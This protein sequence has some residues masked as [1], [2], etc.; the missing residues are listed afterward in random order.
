MRMQE[1]GDPTARAGWRLDLVVGAVVF[2]AALTLYAVTLRGDVQAA[3]AGELQVAAWTLSIPHPPGY[4]L[5]TLLAWAASHLPIGASPYVRISLLSALTSALGAGLLAALVASTRP[6]GAWARRLAGLAAGLALAT[7]VTF[8][9]QATTANIRSLTALFSVG[10]VVAIVA[11][12]ASRREQDWRARMAVNGVSPRFRAAR[13]VLLI[14]AVVLGLGVGHHVS[15]VFPGAVLGAF[16]LIAYLRARASR[17]DHTLGLLAA[18]GVFAAC[19][20][21]WLLLPLRT[22]APSPLDHGNLASL[23]GFLNHALARGFEGDF[24]YFVRAAPELL[25]ERLALLPQLFGFQFSPIALVVMAIGWAGLI[26]RRRP[27][28]LTLAGALGLHLFITLTYRAPQTVEYALPAWVIAVAG[29]G[30]GIAALSIPRTVPATGGG[31]SERD[32]RPGLS[33]RERSTSGSGVSAGLAAR[34]RGGAWLV[35]GAALTIVAI[36]DGISHFA[37][38]AQ[39][40]ADRSDRALAEAA[41]AATPQGGTILG[42]W[43]QITPIWAL[44]T[45]E[46]IRPDVQA[47]YVYPEGAEPYE[48]TFARRAAEASATV[49]SVFNPQF[50][51]RGVCVD[52][53]GAA[54][55]WRTV[56]CVLSVASDASSIVFDQRI[57]LVALEVGVQTEPGASLLARVAWRARGPIQS[58]D[59][60]TIRFLYPDGRLASN[61]DIRLPESQNVGETRSQLIALGIPLDFGPGPLDIR[62]GAYRPANP[63]FVQ[64]ADASGAQFPIAAR[65][66]VVAPSAPPATTRPMRWPQSCASGDRPALIGLDYD[67]GIPGKMRVYT[68]WTTGVV[69]SVTL[70]SP[71]AAPATASPP[72]AD[73]CATLIFDTNPANGLTLDFGG[74]VLALPDPRPGER[75]LPFA[76]GVTL[77]GARIRGDDASVTLDWLSGRALTADYKIS[78]RLSGGRHDGTPA[79]GA[80]PSLKWIAGTRVSDFHP[81]PLRSEERYRVEGD[82]KIYDNFS[83]LPLPVLDPRYERDGAPLFRE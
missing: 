1:L 69:A 33:V 32:R 64:Y 39:L 21:V 72:A 65:T 76:D 57:A 75:Y 4:P 80:V 23:D 29:A 28:G 79:L 49:L 34:L 42:Q 55:I 46:G 22:A 44:Q 71:V 74:S 54:P 7:S 52:P 40:A 78:A 81:M 63:G 58:G 14:C 41:L 38:Y 15:L 8:W 20:L 70:R 25:G 26:W 18:L 36:A 35:L 10:L 13:R 67:L 24:F 77:T 56:P 5:Y 17:R 48:D 62:V 19:Q 30:L 27:L 50:A 43:H 2:A 82:V 16:V 53:V 31:D 83:Q 9:S 45:I 3:D 68:H 11:A 47:R 37:S 59:A 73:G 66:R 6:A 51:A 12:D 61:T 60:L